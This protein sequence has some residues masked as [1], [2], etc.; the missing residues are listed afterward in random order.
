MNSEIKVGVVDY[1]SHRNLVARFKN[2]LTGK[3]ET[4]STGTRKRKEA[5]KFAAKWEA[6]LQEG[7]YKAPSNISW[8]EFRIRYE[9]EVLPGLADGTEEI[10]SGVFN[11]IERILNPQKLATLTAERLSYLMKELRKSGRAESTIKKHM[12]HLKASLN[13]AK[14]QRIISEVPTIKMPHR[15]KSSKRMKGRPVMGEEF[16]RMIG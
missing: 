15:E 12:S 13:W 6:E 2:P 16:D 8:A 11:T 1:G 14:R 5:N 10:A 9:D 4:R 7:R 3:F